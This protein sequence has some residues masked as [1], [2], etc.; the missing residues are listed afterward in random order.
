MRDMYVNF[1]QKIM[2]ADE[3]LYESE[4]DLERTEGQLEIQKN[5]LSKM[6]L[7]AAQAQHNL[8]SSETQHQ[9]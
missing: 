4:Q 2:E 3:K 5:Y 9:Q 1:A 6:Q 8:A 7:S